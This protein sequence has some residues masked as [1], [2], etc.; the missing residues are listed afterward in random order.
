[1]Q[2]RRSSRVIEWHAEAER[3][4]HFIQCG[5]RCGELQICSRGRF[6][7]ISTPAPFPC[8]LQSQPDLLEALDS[9]RGENPFAASKMSIQNGLA[10]GNFVGQ[11]PNSYVGPP[12]KLRD[13]SCGTDDLCPA[14]LPV[15]QFSFRNSVHCQLRFHR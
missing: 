8:P 10:V 12:F 1:M 11:P 4:H 6:E 9:N 14:G 5:W 13:S 2:L 7:R 3:K 15:T